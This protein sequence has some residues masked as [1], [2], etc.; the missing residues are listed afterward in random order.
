MAFEL[1][2]SPEAVEDRSRL[3]AFDRAALDDALE[4]HLRHDPMQLSRT[5]IK[6]LKGMKS[7][8]YRL[9][10]DGLRVLFDV[11]GQEVQILGIVL[12]SEAQDWL[13]ASG[14]P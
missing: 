13:N 6:R 8:Q 12:K 5:R 1:V 4:R 7:P 14:E 9:R 2:L 10:A 3:R 11:V